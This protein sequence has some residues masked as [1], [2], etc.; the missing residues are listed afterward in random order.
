MTPILRELKKWWFF[1]DWK[2]LQLP[3]KNDLEKTTKKHEKR[4]NRPSYIPQYI[5]F[6]AL[7]PKCQKNTIFGPRRKFWF[8]CN[9]FSLIFCKKCE[10]NSDEKNQKWVSSL[11]IPALSVLNWVAPYLKPTKAI[12]AK[13]IWQL[14]FIAS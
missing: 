11:S 1:I 14:T 13:C 2:S 4:E 10:W 8:F 9:F 3:R 7:E 5:D 12:N 6:P